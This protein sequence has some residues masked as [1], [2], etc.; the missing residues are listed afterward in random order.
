MGQSILDL[1][2]S[3]GFAFFVWC[4]FLYLIKEQA[5]NS[6]YKTHYLV[7]KEISFSILTILV[8]GCFVL[9]FMIYHVN[10]YLLII[11]AFAIHIFKNLFKECKAILAK[12][13]E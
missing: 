5:V 3:L 7:C 13:T 11:L 6:H 2:V 8:T 4:S 10:V 1:Q 9:P 12:S